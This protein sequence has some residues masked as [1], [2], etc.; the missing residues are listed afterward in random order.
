MGR[1]RNQGKA[2]R[3]AKAKAREEAERRG[4]DYQTADSSRLSQLQIGGEK[5]KHGFDLKD[6][7]PVG[8][9]RNFPSSFRSAYASSEH[10]SLPRWLVAAKKATMD[11]FADMWEDSTKLEIVI[12]CYLR[13]GTHNLLE[14]KYQYARLFATYARY[15]EQYIAVELK[16]SQAIIDWPKIVDTHE[17]DLHTLVSFFRHRIPCSCL[18]EKYQE[19]KK[20]TKLGHC[21][22]PQCSTPDNRVERSKAKY[23][24]RCLCAT[25]CSRECQE[26]NWPRHK[27]DCDKFAAMISIFEAKQ[28]NM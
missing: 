7:S 25:Y 5:C 1:K 4:N 24:S 16:Q 9:I 14:G 18:D 22:N 10:R 2:R 23:C 6:D 3:A 20:I 15:F 11:E 19:V 28:H 12:S 27:P 21:I 8:F 17:A 13:A 26:A